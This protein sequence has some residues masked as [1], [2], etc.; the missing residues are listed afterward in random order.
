MKKTVSLILMAVAFLMVT[1]YSSA[2]CGDSKTSHAK[3]DCNSKSAKIAVVKFHSDFCGACKK[4]DPKITELKGKFDESVVFVKFD[5]SNDG[6]K[7]KTRTYAEEQGL[8][9]VLES[10]NGTGFMVV[11]DL[12]NKKVL[13]KLDNSLSELDMEKTIKNYL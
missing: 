11:Y 1:S 4:L 12:K 9:S 3:S 6:S 7:A 2:Q 5:F 13:A 8:K 10:N